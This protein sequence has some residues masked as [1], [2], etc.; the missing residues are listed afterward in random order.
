VYDTPLYTSRAVS[1][2]KEKGKILRNDAGNSSVTNQ[3]PLPCYIHAEPRLR[4]CYIIYG[5]MALAGDKNKIK[6]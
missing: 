4:A 1:E 5:W 3:I 6:H 2:A